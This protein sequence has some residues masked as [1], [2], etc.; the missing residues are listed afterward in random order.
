M[1]NLDLALKTRD[2]LVLDMVRVG[3]THMNALTRGQITVWTPGKI[4]Q[5]GRTFS[6]VSTRRAK[7]NLLITHPDQPRV[8]SR[9]NDNHCVDKL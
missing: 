7:V 5:H 2:K 9:I 6:G 8:S 1:G 3:T 4:S